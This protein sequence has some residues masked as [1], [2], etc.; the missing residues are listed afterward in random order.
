MYESINFIV[1]NFTVGKGEIAISDLLEQETL[2]GV[3][4]TTVVAM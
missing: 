3:S 1:S 4:V 2:F